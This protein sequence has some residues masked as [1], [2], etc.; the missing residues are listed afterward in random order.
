MSRITRPNW[1]LERAKII[2]QTYDNAVKNG[3]KL[4]W[5]IDGHNFTKDIDQAYWTM[6][7]THPN[8]FGFYLMY[9]HTLPIL[10]EALKTRK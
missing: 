10:K 6:D 5:F 1:A 7:N 4:V 2:K 8:D 3:D 9:K